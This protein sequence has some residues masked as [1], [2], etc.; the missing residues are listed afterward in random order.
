MHDYLRSIYVGQWLASRPSRFTILDISSCTIEYEAGWTPH[1]VWTLCSRWRY[2]TLPGI[3][4]RFLGLPCLSVV[5][6]PN[7]LSGHSEWE[8]LLKSSGK[9]FSELGLKSTFYAWGEWLNCFVDWVQERNGKERTR[10][11]LITVLR[12]CT[13]RLYDVEWG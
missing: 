11:H 3:E 4:T 8:A 6:G 5:T 1:F 10:C 7:T 2:V 13:M 12:N 9:S